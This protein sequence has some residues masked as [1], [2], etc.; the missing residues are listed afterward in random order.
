[1]EEG[2]EVSFLPDFWSSLMS[3]KE[4]LIE[5][6]AVLDKKYVPLSSEVYDVCIHA[7]RYFDI[8]A[9]IHA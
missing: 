2:G 8:Y 9:H 3:V 6:G 7:S 5:C 1:M 4:W